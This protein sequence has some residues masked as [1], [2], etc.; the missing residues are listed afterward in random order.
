[1]RRRSRWR[2]YFEGKLT[3]EARSKGDRAPTNPHKK[4]RC[5]P[6]SISRL[7]RDRRILSSLMAGRCMRQPLLRSSLLKRWP[8]IITL[9][10]AWASLWCLNYPGIIDRCFRFAEMLIIISLVTVLLGAVGSRLEIPF[11]IISSLAASLYLIIPLGSWFVSIGSIR[12]SK[13]RRVYSAILSILH[14]PLV[15]LYTATLSSM[16]LATVDIDREK[17]REKYF[18]AERRKLTAGCVS[19]NRYVSYETMKKNCG[20]RPPPQIPALPSRQ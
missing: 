11:Q 20:L 7:R 8:G 1:M 2:G 16:L 15:V 12:R 9:L 4:R 14:A 5:L 17:I 10:R 13:Y 6:V 3:F 18:E 19:V